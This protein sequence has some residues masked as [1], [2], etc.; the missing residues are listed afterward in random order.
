MRDKIYG[1][2]EFQPR[3]S[4]KKRQTRN[5]WLRT[6]AY[7]LRTLQLSNKETEDYTFTSIELHMNILLYKLKV[8]LAILW[9]LKITN[10]SHCLPSMSKQLKTVPYLTSKKEVMLHSQLLLYR[11][12]RPLF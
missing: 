3:E 10:A 8:V 4:K 6:P 1:K 9:S 7:D 12:Q 5:N 11:F 2:N